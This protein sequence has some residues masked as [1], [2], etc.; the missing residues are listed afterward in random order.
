MAA[1]ATRT[2][3][4]LFAAILLAGCGGGSGG[5]DPVLQPDAPST[6]VTPVPEPEP[7]PE[8]EPGP[9]PEPTPDPA[10]AAGRTLF[11]SGQVRPIALSAD[12]NRLFVVN[13]PAH[14]L[15]LF[16]IADGQLSPAGSVPV[17]LEPVAVAAAS[18]N[19][20]WVVNHLSDSISIVRLDGAAPRVVR[21]LLVGDEPRDIV[22]AGPGN[23]RAFITA[24]YRGQNH[25]GFSAADLKTPGLGRADVWIFDADA[26]GA[27]PGGE[28]LAIITLFADSARGLARSADGSRVYAAAVLSGNQTT[29]LLNEAEVADAKPGPVQNHEG[30]R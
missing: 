13:T 3:T 17:G 7:E 29:T 4:A 22:F 1:R 18:A 6:P 30:V 26:P 16:D 24:A 9:E 20:I 12:G 23:R 5:G 28:P 11:E 14:R 21:T 8:P 25:P 2:V 19:E 10:D 15:E 27:G